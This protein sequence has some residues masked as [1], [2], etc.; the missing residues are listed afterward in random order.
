MARGRLQ[1]LPN[2][3]LTLHIL[4][5]MTVT[6]LVHNRNQLRATEVQ[7]KRHLMTTEAP[8]LQLALNSRPK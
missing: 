5:E 1:G 7:I 8:R 4:Q 6:I 2:P 3:P